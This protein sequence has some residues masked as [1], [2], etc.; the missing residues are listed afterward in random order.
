[1]KQNVFFR[2][3]T[4]M[5]GFLLM[6]LALAVLMGPG[7]QSQSADDP[8]L[9]KA[10]RDPAAANAV[11]LIAQGR[12]VF[13]FDTFGDEAFWGDMLRLHQAIE[14]AGLG[15]VGPGLSPK[16]VLA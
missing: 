10:I 8:S 4:A 13:R 2:F 16:Q 9:A 11:N 6:G 14:G 12:Q 3:G 7:A 5:A 15:G 1:M